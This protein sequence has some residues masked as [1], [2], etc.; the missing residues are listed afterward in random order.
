[1]SFDTYRRASLAFG[2]KAARRRAH[3]STNGAANLITAAGIKCTRGSLLAWERGVGYTS[4]EPF[5]SDL[6]AI[7]KVYGCAVGDLFVEP[8][9]AVSDELQLIAADAG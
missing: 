2:M 1:M 7:A 8:Q 5:A 9:A 3:L 4:R 6:P